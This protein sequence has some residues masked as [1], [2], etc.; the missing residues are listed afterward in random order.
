[1]RTKLRSWS[2]RARPGHTLAAFGILALSACIGGVPVVT[3]VQVNSYDPSMLSYAAGNG[4]MHVEIYGNPF[5]GEQ[6]AFEEKVANALTKA[7]RGP[8]FP[9]TPEKAANQQTVYRLVMA[10]NTPHPGYRICRTPGGE[11]AAGSPVTVYAALCQGGRSVTSLSGQ[12]AVSG[13]D[14]PAFD[15][16]MT[17]VAANL[18][19]ARNPDMD[20]ANGADFE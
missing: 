19:P 17:Q 11:A 20:G 4:G 16:L 2:K 9:V 18:L 14:D 6:A 8:D 5:G 13:P 15:S 10:F 1:M 3:P 12:I 7:H